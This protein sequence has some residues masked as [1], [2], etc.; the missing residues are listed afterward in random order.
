MNAPSPAP[1]LVTVVLKD[2][3]I[4][5][6]ECANRNELEILMAEIISDP[7]VASYCVYEQIKSSYPAP[8]SS[9]DRR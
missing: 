3:E 1:I 6:E 8:S 9:D 2:G 7:Q 5:H 4:C